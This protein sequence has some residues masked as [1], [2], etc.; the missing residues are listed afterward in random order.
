MT[1][2]RTSLIAAAC[3]LFAGA[4]FAQVNLIPYQ[5]AGWAWAV[6]PR[7]TNDATTTLVTAPATLTGDATATY[8]NSSWRNIGV[9]TSG[10]FHNNTVLDGAT[11]VVDRSC[12][13]L[14]GGASGTGINGGPFQF[15]AGRHTLELRV[16]SGGVV[17]ETSET[18]NA[19]ARQWVWAP[20]V[21]GTGT[22]SSRAAPPDPSG[23]RSVIPAGQDS[24]DNCDGVRFTTALGFW[25]LFYE[26]SPDAASDYMLR[27]FEPSTGATNGFANALCTSSRGGRGVE[28]VVANA[29]N[30]GAHSY[31]V[32]IYRAAGTGGCY[33][34]HAAS[35]GL[36]WGDSISDSFAQDEMAKIYEVSVPAAGAGGIS[37]WLHLATIDPSV[38]VVWV[39]RTFTVG[40]LSSISPSVATDENGRVRLDVPGGESGYYGLILFRDPD[41]GTGPRSF[42]LKVGPSVPNLQPYAPPGWY[43][44]IVP[45][46]DAAG[47]ASAV[48]KPDTLPSLNT[49]LYMNWCV[50]NS[51]VI[52]CPSTSATAIQIDGVTQSSFTTPALAVGG[53]A[54]WNGYYSGIS[55]YS[56]RH[57]VALHANHA[58]VF[59]EENLLDNNYADQYCWGPIGT[60]PLGDMGWDPSPPPL[61]GGVVDYFNTH[62]GTFYY[63]NLG[64][65]LPTASPTA[66]WQGYIIGPMAGDDYDLALC[67]T[68]HGTSDGMGEALA[69]SGWGAGQTDYVLANLNVTPRRPFDITVLNYGGTSSFHPQYVESTT[70]GVAGQLQL[71]PYVGTYY[72]LMQLREWYFAVGDW[73]IYLT[74]QSN[75]GKY[76]L[77]FHQATQVYAI[78][79]Q[80]DSVYPI[81]GGDCVLHVNVATAGWCCVA[82]WA[83]TY[84]S[85]ANMKYQLA[86]MPNVSAAPDTPLVPART[87]LLEASPNP[88]NPQTTIAFDLAATGHAAVRV[89]DLQGAVVRTLVDTDLAAGHQQVVWDGASESGHPLPSGTYFARLEAGGVVEVRK[90]ALVK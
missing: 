75:G 84:E 48:A 82:V 16:D 19:V 86:I 42:G 63:N 5:P 51:G 62:T 6:V 88:F 41:W 60:A 72:D 17:S 9:G 74:N 21:I 28:A 76:G 85:A 52:A 34:A 14:A 89:Y 73:N 27:A 3:L 22:R 40:G 79:N 69:F 87:T 1:A 8:M 68:L 25:S 53:D 30:V 47:T 59:G 50:R 32:G 61:I 15:Q 54:R 29:R 46:M 55:P 81:D 36:A 70:H 83:Q 57:T 90:L 12:P 11:I 20:A 78:K 71:A 26:W 37:A 45:R 64:R 10:T 77:T 13:A 2:L 24:Y 4:A 7:P 44:S 56:G 67:E 33:A 38:V 49:G 58:A 43:A 18:D 66:W 80:A 65:R 31:D 35:T 39:D 23:G